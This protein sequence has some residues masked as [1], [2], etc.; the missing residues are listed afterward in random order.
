MKVYRTRPRLAERSIKS[1][2]KLLR[3]KKSYFYAEYYTLF[4]ESCRRWGRKIIG[5][6]SIKDTT[7][8]LTESSK[9]D[10]WDF[11]EIQLTIREPESNL[12]PLYICYSCIAQCFCG[13]PNRGS[14]GCFFILFP[15]LGN[16]VLIPSCL[17]LPK[18][19]H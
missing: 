6:G 2:R 3:R 14:V 8:K 17:I 1:T 16:L 11:T 7:R 15:T 19:K 18:Y 13:I 12:C 5:A 9:L 4:G 10:S